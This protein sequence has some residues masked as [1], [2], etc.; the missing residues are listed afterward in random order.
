VECALLGPIISFATAGLKRIPF[1]ANNPKLV[2]LIFSVLLN[3]GTAFYGYF[4]GGAALP[5]GTILTCVL[6]SFG[7][8][9]A[10]H[11]VVTKPIAAALGQ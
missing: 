8:S 3:A 10:T 5:L 7:V 11:E 6:S 9:V 1:V 4:H 2:A